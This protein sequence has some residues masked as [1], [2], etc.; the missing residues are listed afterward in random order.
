MNLLNN[1]RLDQ[2]TVVLILRGIG[3]GVLECS[4]HTCNDI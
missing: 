2:L 4:T 1:I 3:M